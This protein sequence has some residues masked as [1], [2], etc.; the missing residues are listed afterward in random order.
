MNVH[1]KE[2]QRLLIVGPSGVGKSS[3]LR[4]IAGLWRVG[5]GQITRPNDDEVLFLPQRP[6]CS[7]GSLREQLT[8]PSPPDEVNIADEE[9]LEILA[10]V[11][12]YSLA[13][14]F[15]GGERG[16]KFCTDTP[17]KDNSGRSSAISRRKENLTKR[18]VTL[19]PLLLVCVIRSRCG[20]RLV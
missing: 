17:R 7:L 8:Y 20:S 5:S 13:E 12:L 4:A 18:L 1:V 16:Q 6:Y 9:L 10:R 2:G 11:Q 14:Q 15:G 3:L 19:I